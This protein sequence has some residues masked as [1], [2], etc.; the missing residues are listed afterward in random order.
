[1]SSK[2]NP[3]LF[4]SHNISDQK[5]VQL[6]VSMF[7]LGSKLRGD[8]IV[9]SSVAGC[10]LGS[11]SKIDETV[12]KLAVRAK[13]FIAVLSRKSVLSN[14]VKFELGAR[15]G[16]GKK[17]R[18][19]GIPGYSI[20]SLGPPFKGCV[21]T[22]A[23]SE[24]EL[25]Q[26]LEICVKE[27][28]GLKLDFSHVGCGAQR[29]QFLELAA[30]IETIDQSEHG[31]VSRDGFLSLNEKL[32][33]EVFAIEL[34]PRP[35]RIRKESTGKIIVTVDRQ[36]VKE[37]VISNTGKMVKVKEFITDKNRAAILK[38]D[39]EVHALLASGNLGPNPIDVNTPDLKIP[40][41]WAS[42]GVLSIINRGKK[43]W[44]PMFFR[45]IRP[46]GWNISLGQTERWF[47]KKAEGY[48][49]EDRAAFM[50]EL[51]EPF[52]YIS[53]EFVEESLIVSETPSRR[54]QLHLRPFELKNAGLPG[55]RG[56]LHDEEHL[57]LR[58]T[59]DKL[60]I[61]R[62]T[63]KRK[64]EDRVGTHCDLEVIGE[65]GVLLPTEDVLVCFSL[66]D[67]G[68][69]IVKVF[70]YDMQE[71]EHMIDGE[72]IE[73]RHPKTDDLTREL[74]RMPIALMSLDYIERTFSKRSDWQN[75]TEG[76]QPSI[77]IP[78][79]SAPGEG[80]IELF[81]WD[82]ERRMEILSS[83]KGS[84]FELER[85]EQWYD[86]F[87]ENFLDAKGRPS[88][89]KPSRLFVPGT[90]KILNLYFRLVPDA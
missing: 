58:R 36:D 64:V 20:E 54:V 33:G 19:L 71:A 75:Y 70:R 14:W 13:G 29:Q 63:Q 23:T 25:G 52:H 22:S 66:L 89:A 39:A 81:P 60:D 65:D 37:I 78:A 83:G 90:A 55:Q 82:V 34:L 67:L 7:C 48:V 47:R 26:L 53:R 50:A 11:G 2:S 5:L 42:G 59:N 4:I 15:W 18:L 31:F 28:L 6:L 84:W 62:S 74:V 68:I 46:F 57:Q 30:R 1:M 61:I 45:D 40:F 79:D 12:A 87:R 77:E 69:E 10:T 32:P 85:Y 73:K 16:S 17:F 72:I 49:E 21:V 41:R 88:C 76:P 86:C 51:R 44:V 27:D 35:V 3:M 24:A 43:K 56:F 8:Q 38:R 9:C 80:D